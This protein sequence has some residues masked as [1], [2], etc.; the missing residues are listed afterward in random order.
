MARIASREVI[1][2]FDAYLRRT[3]TLP[4]PIIRARIKDLQAGRLRA[5]DSSSPAFRRT[6]V[7]PELV[8][9]GATM[10]EETARGHGAASAD[11]RA[12]RMRERHPIVRAPIAFPEHA[13]HAAEVPA[14]DARARLAAFTQYVAE[15]VEAGE[16]PWVDVPD[17]HRM[18]SLHDDRGNVFLG[19][20]VRR[21]ALDRRSGKALMRL[22]LAAEAAS[23]NLRVGVYT[24]KRGLYYQHQARLADGEAGQVES[25]R[26]IAALATLLGV[27]R[28]SLGFVEAR[29]GLMFGWLVLR[30]G[31]QILDV[32][33][34]GPRGIGVPRFTDDVEIAPTQT[35]FSSSRSTPSP[36][37]LRRS[38]GGRPPAASSCAQ[39]DSHRS[40]RAS[41]WARWSTPSASRPCSASTGILAA[42]KSPS[43]L[44]TGPSR[45][46][47]RRPGSPATTCGGPGSIRPRSSAPATPTPGF[48]STTTSVRPSAGCLPIRRTRTSTAACAKNSPSSSTWEPRS[49]WT[50]FSTTG[51]SL[52]TTS[53][54]RSST[55]SWSSSEGR[56]QRAPTHRSSR[57]LRY[58]GL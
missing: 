42:F 39:R 24:T 55:P 50:R 17:L 13:Q 21:L 52:T 8:A 41:S 32:S 54:R 16:V 5:P 56:L 35:S 1:A 3:A 45:R 37:V 22:L 28:R 47:S 44:R 6:P 31:E 51:A 33:K 15:R 36:F 11:E 49:N 30:D 19:Q 2:S 26:A 9:T 58:S 12:A 25:D 7:V 57:G 53:R 14:D 18:N 38:A 43:R 23:D 34:L 4:E 20:N 46:R 10:R 27:R 48:R 29:R 40:R